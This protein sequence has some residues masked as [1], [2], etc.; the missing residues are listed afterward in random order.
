MKPEIG[1][2]VPFLVRQIV[3]QRRYITSS[4][5]RDLED[6]DG[7]EARKLPASLEQET[8]R[9]LGK[10]FADMYEEMFAF[11]ERGQEFPIG[12]YTKVASA[13][14][15]PVSDGEARSQTAV[16]LLEQIV[17]DTVVRVVQGE[18]TK[19]RCSLFAR[20]ASDLSDI[21]PE[22]ARVE[23]DLF[24]SKVMEAD[25]EVLKKQIND[26]VVGARARVGL[27]MPVGPDRPSVLM[28]V[29]MAI[30][31]KLFG[32]PKAVTPTYNAARA[33]F[34]CYWQQLFD[35]YKDGL[36]VAVGVIWQDGNW[37]TEVRRL[38]V[39]VRKVIQT[40]EERDRERLRKLR[41]QVGSGE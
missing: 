33:A 25:A 18:I 21:H 3:R 13:N 4:V 17:M 2:E 9:A 12:K 36:R 16:Q 8:T 22:L 23:Q 28:A 11:V 20:L 39:L 1:R 32:L 14:L 40:A 5:L 7:R 34:K 27:Y 35:A 41:V 30:L 19:W 10:L 31:R 29:L 24:G 38:A 26:A 6:E 37:N 15:S